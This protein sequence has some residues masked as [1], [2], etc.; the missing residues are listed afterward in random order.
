[1]ADDSVKDIGN[2]L[3]NAARE[4]RS[5][6]EESSSFKK[7]IENA[8][9]SSEGLQKKFGTAK[10]IT[11]KMGKNLKVFY[12][13]EQQLLQL[14]K[15][16][17]DNVFKGLDLEKKTVVATKGQQA[18]IVALIKAKARLQSE[19]EKSLQ[20]QLSLLK[21]QAIYHENTNSLSSKIAEKWEKMGGAKGV[22]MSGLGIIGSFIVETFK[23]IWAQLDKYLLPAWAEFERAIGDTNE[24]THRLKGE[25]VSMGRQFQRVGLNFH[26]GAKLVRDVAAGMGTLKFPDEIFDQSMRLNKIF[27]LSVESATRLQKAWLRSE[28]SLTGL[29]KTM[30][31]A[32]DLANEYLVPSSQIAQEWANN[33]DWIARFGTRNSMEMA[34]STTKI[35]DLSLSVKS[36]N[37]A[38]G[39]QMDTF[40][41]TADVAAKLNAIFGTH[42][43]SYELMLQTDPAERMIMLRNE[44][45]KQGKSWDKISVFEKNVITTEMGVSDEMAQIA[46]ASKDARSALEKYGKEQKKQA[47]FNKR[48]EAS[49]GRVREM[50]VNWP[51]LMER[52]FRSIGG[53]IVRL[54]KLDDAFTPTLK[55][56]QL[57]EKAMIGLSEGIDKMKVEPIMDLSSF[58]RDLDV[59]KM[60]DFGESISNVAK[61]LDYMTAPLRGIA[62]IGKGIEW[63]FEKGEESHIVDTIEAGIKA[64]KKAGT[65]SKTYFEE[66]KKQFP[67]YGGMIKRQQMAENM[68]D[69]LITKKGEIIKFNQNDNI[70]ATKSPISRTA[71]GATAT[72]GK[73]SA[74]QNIIIEAAP[75]YLDSRKIAEAVFR[76][77]RK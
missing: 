46:F 18:L 76:Q 5:L 6:S 20:K 53:L 72:A 10:N 75:I 73:G 61:G 74:E 13:M 22:I 66:L 57:F 52:L 28:G 60:S 37:A 58:V 71:S 23:S 55:G 7:N 63:L 2:M 9:L 43:N 45:E 64:Q 33:I 69:A 41:K 59:K 54:F 24:R 27:G 1:M 25:M 62:N 56:G 77:S 35:L 4:L 47:D 51:A 48:W 70:M 26:E 29:N 67:E 39:K 14:Q 11:E 38:F 19:A 68:Q 40:D 16:K 12:K 21:A 3:A 36:V 17:F 8:L 65:L 31:S 44:L 34:K 50:V 49:L 32:D 42:I 30:K 15:K